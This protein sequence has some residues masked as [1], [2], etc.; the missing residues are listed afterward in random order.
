LFLDSYLIDYPFVN[1]ADT[2]VLSLSSDLLHP[3]IQCSVDSYNRLRGTELLTNA[4]ATDGNGWEPACATADAC[5]VVGPASLPEGAQLFAVRTPLSTDTSCSMTCADGLVCVSGSCVRGLGARALGGGA[6]FDLRI[7]CDPLTSTCGGPLGTGGTW[8]ETVDLTSGRY[9]LS[10]YEQENGAACAPRLE[11]SVTP[12]DG[13]VSAAIGSGA[14]ASSDRW[15]NAGSPGNWRRIVTSVTVP[16]GGGR[17]RVAWA[18]AS[19]LPVDTSGN[20]HVTFGAPQLEPVDASA[21]VARPYFPTDAQGTAPVGLCP[22]PTG[23]ALRS[24][25]T[26]RC[27]QLCTTGLGGSCPDG[28]ESEQCFWE[29]HFAFDIGAIERGDLIPTGGFA[30]GNFNYRA[31]TLAINLV[32]TG[33]RDCSAVADSAACYA[34]GFI[35]FSLAHDGPFHVRNHFGQSI[36][37]ANLSPIVAGRIS[38]AK[39]LTA[40]RYLTNPI[41]SADRALL[42]DE[43]RTEFQGRPLDGQYTLRIH[44][45][46]GLRWDRIEDVQIV[47]NY[48]YWTRQER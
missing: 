45:T 15:S 47:L 20:L 37:L 28:A 13:G 42:S 16:P 2:V 8:G 29:T 3:R 1:G 36:D 38:F 48:R 9:L 17:Y 33:V 22:D 41:S 6:A 24:L 32:G 18:V 26:Y 14:C 23:G 30:V 11:A 46:P 35:P 21:A 40:E 27:A 43:W 31:D 10:W 4:G 7:H 25:F 5:P 34:S 12:A 44:D 19:G 39:A